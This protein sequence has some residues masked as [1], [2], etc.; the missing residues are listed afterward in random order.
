MFKFLK[1]I[2]NLYASR[3]GLWKELFKLQQTSKRRYKELLHRIHILEQKQKKLNNNNPIVVPYHVITG[4]E[5]ET[6][7]AYQTETYST[8][9]ERPSERVINVR[10]V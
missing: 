8:D 10:E 4:R 9:S 7:P 3:D 2:T 1:D 6:F 5:N